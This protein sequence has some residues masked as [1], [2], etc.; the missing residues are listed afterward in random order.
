MVDANA[1]ETFFEWSTYLA[2][3]QHSPGIKEVKCYVY[4]HQGQKRDL[5]PLIKSDGSYLVGSQDQRG[6][7]INVCREL[8]N[9]AGIYSH[10]QVLFVFH[11]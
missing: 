9:S 10:I 11:Y 3:K 5:S 1:C 6:F 7:Y 4:D 2:C 8:P